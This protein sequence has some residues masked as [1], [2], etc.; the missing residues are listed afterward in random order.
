MDAPEI[1]RFKGI[2]QKA[3]D[4]EA[5]G[6]KVKANI[7]GW[8]RPPVVAGM[9]PDLRGEREGTIRVGIVGFEGEIEQNTYSNLVDY[10]GKNK[11]VSLRLYSI[12]VDD[13]ISLFKMIS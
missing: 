10:A 7:G 4:W 9:I 5:E 13:K 11:N 6:F 8:D 2:N 12:G 3:K 1:R